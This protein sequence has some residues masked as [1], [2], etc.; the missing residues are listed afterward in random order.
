M[1]HEKDVVT[2]PNEEERDLMAQN[3]Y[4]PGCIGYLDGTDVKLSEAPILDKDSFYDK[5]KVL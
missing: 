1:E 4:L 5:N 2:W 3:E